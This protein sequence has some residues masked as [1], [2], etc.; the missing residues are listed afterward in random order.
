MIVT[1]VNFFLIVLTNWRNQTAFLLKL[2]IESKNKSSFNQN[3]GQLAC[4][5]VSVQNSTATNEPDEFD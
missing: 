1:Q 3:L 4:F 5:E 2:I